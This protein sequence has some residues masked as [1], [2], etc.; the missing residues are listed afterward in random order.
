M[1]IHITFLLP[2]FLI[3]PMGCHTNLGGAIHLFSSDLN[4]NHLPGRSYHCCMK[5]LITV[6]LR[7]G[8][9]VL[10]PFMDRCKKLMD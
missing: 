9:E 4:L 2:I 8:K 1:S 5:R 10:K 3:F 7:P 6:D